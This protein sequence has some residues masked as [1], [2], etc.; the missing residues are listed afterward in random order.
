M[1][2]NLDFDAPSHS[3]RWHVSRHNAVVKRSKY[4]TKLYFVLPTSHLL[5]IWFTLSPCLARRVLE[6]QPNQIRN[7]PTI[8]IALKF[9]IFNR[10][11]GYGQK[12][13]KFTIQN[14]HKIMDNTYRTYTLRGKALRGVKLLADKL[15]H[16][17]LD[18]GYPGDELVRDT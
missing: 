3:G 18:V 9:R 8:C 1:R 5:R 11:L 10:G 2:A 14:T 15:L 17:I 13:W 12:W 7:R 6:L 4:M 16:S